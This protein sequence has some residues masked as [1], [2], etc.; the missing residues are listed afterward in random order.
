MIETLFITS[1]S[2]FIGVA[3]VV[4]IEERRAR[5]FIG[6]RVRVVM[7]QK[8]D[9]LAHQFE[10][11]WKHVS[12]A[13]VQLGWYYSIHSVLRTILTVLVSLYDRL[14]QLFERNRE[15]T[16]QLRRDLKKQ[17]SSTHLS[18]IAEHKERVTLTPEEQ[19]TLKR[20]KLEHDH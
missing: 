18:H 8:I 4:A 9:Y 6:G 12:R 20:E 11:H 10:N 7:D 13:V 17:L 14:E 15:R 19:A 5:R 2:L 1:A 3:I 16:K